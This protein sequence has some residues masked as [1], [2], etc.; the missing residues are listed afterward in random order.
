MLKSFQILGCSAGIPTI[1]R[2]A[3]SSIFSLQNC[4]IMIDCGEGTYLLWKQSNYKWKNL[5]YIFIIQF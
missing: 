5:K 4:D 2:G 1:K 3:S